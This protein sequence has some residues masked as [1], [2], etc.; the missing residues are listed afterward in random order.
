VPAC[1]KSPIPPPLAIQVTALLGAGTS[2]AMPAALC[3]AGAASGAA[4]AWR[5]ERGVREGYAEAE[6]RAPPP[7]GA[8]AARVPLR[9]R[10]GGGEACRAAPQCRMQ[11]HAPRFQAETLGSPGC[12]PVPPRAA[13]ALGGA[14]ARAVFVGAGRRAVAGESARRLLPCWLVRGRRRRRA[15]AAAADRGGAA[16]R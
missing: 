9:P 5:P 14:A 7:D 13:R 11:P 16:R 10:L 1:P 12:N 8:V 2:W 6:G 3:A 15:L 4:A